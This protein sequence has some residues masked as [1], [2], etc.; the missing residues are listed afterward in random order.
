MWYN[1]IFVLF[2]ILLF[3][4]LGV[5]Y[6]LW[7]WFLYVCLLN[8]LGTTT[9]LSS[10]PSPVVHTSFQYIHTHLV[11]QQ[12][13]LLKEIFLELLIC[14]N[15]LLC[16]WS[17][18]VTLRSPYSICFFFCYTFSKISSNLSSNFSFLS[19]FHFCFY[20]ICH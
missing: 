20:S 19:F 15:L 3:C 16:T 14:S 1:I 17:T 9:N 13:Y 4:F 8:F 18:T 2:C 11:V 7:F 5:L 12:F 10:K 6:L